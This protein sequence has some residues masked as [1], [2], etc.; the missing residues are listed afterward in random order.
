MEFLK[1]PRH[2]LRNK[3]FKKALKGYI[4]PAFVKNYE[5]ICVRVLL[6]NQEDNI[7]KK[8][9][10]LEMILEEDE[11][12]VALFSCITALVN[13]V[14]FRNLFT[15]KNVLQGVITLLPRKLNVLQKLKWTGN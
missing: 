14:K 4:V 10:E 2:Q 7:W 11:Y 8:R 1:K 6:K 13:D 9:R 3:V 12:I 5:A 15:G